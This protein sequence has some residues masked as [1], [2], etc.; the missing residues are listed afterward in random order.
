MELKK[1]NLHMDRIKCRINTQITLEEDKNISDRNPDAVSILMDH[2]KIVIE[3]VRP[4]T[5]N[6]LLRGKFLYEVLCQ[7]DMPEKRLYR[8]QGEIPWE[9]KIKVEGMESMD[10]PKIE[11]TIEDMKSSLIHSRK[12]NIRALLNFY[13]LANELYDEEILVDV[14]NQGEVEVKREMREVS[15]LAVD[16]K[17]IYRIKEELE[18]PS[19]LP[20]IGEVLWKFVELG[21]V[22]AKVL[23]D[24]IRLQGEIRLFLLYE[25]EGEYPQ[26]KSYETTIPFSGNIECTD[27]SSNM[28]GEI[29]PTVS[30]QNL[31]VKEDYDG[32][33]RMLELEMVLD[34]PI[35][36]YKKQ[37]FEEITDVYGIHQEVA[38]QYRE[39]NGRNVREP[40]ME[41]CKITKEVKIKNTDRKILQ[42]CHMDTMMEVPEIRQ[43]DSKLEIQGIV[44]VR[45]LYLEDGE[46]ESYEV[47]KKEI[48]FLCEMENLK[49]PMDCNFHARPMLE[50]QS[51][52]IADEN[53]I[54]IKMVIGIELWPEECW[55]RSGICDVQPLAYSEEAAEKG[56]GI[57]VYIPTKQE[58]LWEIGKGY[59]IS[60]KA[61]KDIN[62]LTEAEEKNLYRMQ[63]EK[64]QKLLLVRG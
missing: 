30:Y 13:I 40:Y 9:E 61:I 41:R 56:A 49:I 17:D 35:Q 31:S 59:G 43:V 39:Q 42:I 1:L 7:S 32:E 57:V 4:M 47:M 14:Q 16:K 64:G 22:E 36:L 54:E 60:L 52:S 8:V 3:E 25:S 62:G 58:T 48:P 29:V 50:Q 26:I 51:A 28:I 23:E 11:A 44:K 45:I 46:E 18:L 55:K 37:S 53:S 33:D 21:K 5:D 6:V 10:T 24:S 20:P 15:V 27:C 63:V 34:V 12:L 19:F 38:A 2:G